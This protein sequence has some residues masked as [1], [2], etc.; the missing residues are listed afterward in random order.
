MPVATAEDVTD[1]RPVRAVTDLA[2]RIFVLAR[3]GTSWMHLRRSFSALYV[4]DYPHP[5]TQGE[6][7][8]KSTTSEKTTNTMK[9]IKVR[10]VGDIRLTAPPVSYCYCNCCCC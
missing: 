3:A 1:S 10:K 2:C 8:M 7:M 4:R 9:T 6:R 5:E